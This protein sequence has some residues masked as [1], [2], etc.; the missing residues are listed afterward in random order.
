MQLS[1]KTTKNLK[2]CEFLGCT[3][4]F[5]G[6][7]T[8]KYCDDPRCIELR[9]EFNKNKKKE[10]ISINNDNIVINKN[11]KKKLK[12]GQTLIVRCRAHSPEG[13]CENKYSIVIDNSQYIYPKYC[14]CHR[15]EFK[16]KM[17]EKGL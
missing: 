5:I 10:N 7:A 14:V 2:T 6:F 16:R 9:V 1:N 12:H 15:N 17:F 11:Y 3:N 8:K 4:S 13:R